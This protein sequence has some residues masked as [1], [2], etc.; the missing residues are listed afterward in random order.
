MNPHLTRSAIR[1]L[2]SALLLLLLIPFAH[3][4]EPVVAEKPSGEPVLTDQQK[5]QKAFEI[6]W[7][8]V[9][10]RFYDRNFGGVD[11]LQARKRYEQLVAAATS[12]AQVHLLLQEM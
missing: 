9:N 3:A 2:Y 5:R 6:V 8:T 7:Q 1:N 12:D 11:W 10:E 4:Q